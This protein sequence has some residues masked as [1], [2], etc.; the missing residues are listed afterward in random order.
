MAERAAIGL[1]AETGSLEAYEQLLAFQAG[2][3]NHPEPREPKWEGIEK[4]PPERALRW[5]GG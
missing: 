1:E 4:R 5:Q 3:E 2:R